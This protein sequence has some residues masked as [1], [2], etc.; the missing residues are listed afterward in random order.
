MIVLIVSAESRSSVQHPNALAVLKLAG[1]IRFGDLTAIHLSATH[2]RLLV[3]ETYSV[4][5]YRHP[6]A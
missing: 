4:V 1:K 5:T 6:D 3:G 2:L